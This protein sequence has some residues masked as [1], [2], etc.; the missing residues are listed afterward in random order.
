MTMLV[1]PVEAA[2]HEPL[3]QPPAEGPVGWMDDFEREL[4]P[5][6]RSLGNAFDFLWRAGE[7]A[8]G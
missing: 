5:V 7:S 2:P 6:G 4:K 1:L 8:D 3:E